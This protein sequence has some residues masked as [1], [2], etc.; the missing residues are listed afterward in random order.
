[1][2]RHFAWIFPVL[3][4]SGLLGGSSIGL[5]QEGRWTKK[6]DMP[7]TRSGPVTVVVNDKIYAMGGEIKGGYTGNVEEYDPAMDIWV[8]KASMSTERG[9]FAGGV[10]N[11]TI[12]A[13]GGLA[14]GALSTVEEY[15]L[16]ANKWKKKADMPTARADL[17]TSVVDD[18]IYAIG[19]DDW[20]GVMPKVE[21][22]TPAKNRWNDAS[23][24]PTSRGQLSASTVNGKVYAIGG[25]HRV[26]MAGFA[27]AD[28]VLSTVEEYNPKTRKWTK[29]ADMPTPRSWLATVVVN[30]KIY[31]I[32]GYAGDGEYLSTVEIYDPAADIWTKGPDM[33]T[34]RCLLAASAVN[35]KIY[36]IGGFTSVGKGAKGWMFHSIVEE[37]DTGFAGQSIE[38]KGKLTTFW[39]NIK[40][41]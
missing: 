41:K 38:A 28:K 26:P 3:M 21:E 13:I 32:G 12:Y 6:A 34:A 35:G 25:A 33:P 30:E 2:K 10:V 4:L 29:R 37:Y 40:S 5:A 24:M 23:E 7:T 8:P 9:Y 20:G 16:A 11:D 36:A 1:M 31:A 14:V 22:Y 19:G 15:N 17:T 39:G 27:D 18:K